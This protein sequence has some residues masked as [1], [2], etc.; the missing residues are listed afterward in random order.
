MYTSKQI[1]TKLGISLR[2]LYYWELRGVVTPEL[3][4]LGTREFK[5]YSE[6][7]LVR[8]RSIKRSLDSGYTLTAAIKKLGDSE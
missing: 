8:L 4:S 3:I 7:D 6:T 5:R 2:Q 1:T